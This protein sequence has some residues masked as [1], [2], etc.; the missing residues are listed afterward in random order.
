MTCISSNCLPGRCCVTVFPTLQPGC[1]GAGVNH[2]PP[3]AG[4]SRFDAI[5]SHI[6]ILKGLQDLEKSAFSA[7]VLLENCN[8]KQNTFQNKVSANHEHICYPKNFHLLWWP[9]HFL[10][11]PSEAVSQLFLFAPVFSYV[12][13]F[14]SN[15][16]LLAFTDVAMGFPRSFEQLRP[17]HP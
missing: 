2:A 5:S 17:L 10:V 16:S 13:N 11:W 8:H 14:A 6:S 15:L 3:L 4:C 12:C 1:C 9:N 7:N